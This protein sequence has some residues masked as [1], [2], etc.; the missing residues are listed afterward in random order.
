MI[1]HQYLIRLKNFEKTLSFR[2]YADRSTEAGYLD[3]YRT[4]VPQMCCGGYHSRKTI[5]DSLR[6]ARDCG[7]DIER[8]NL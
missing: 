6:L 4:F 2:V 8:V 5:A 1:S 3:I 7:Y